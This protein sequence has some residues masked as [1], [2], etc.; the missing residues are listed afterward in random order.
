MAEE[1]RV[2]LSRAFGLVR[3]R[4]GCSRRLSAC[5]SRMADGC[6]IRTHGGFRLTR[7]QNERLN[8]LEPT[9]QELFIMAGAAGFEPAISVLETGVLPLTLCPYQ[10]GTA[11][12][13]RTYEGQ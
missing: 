2:E 11:G 4:N 6:G 13:T 7:F 3:F 5:S 1:E 8:P 12:R 9:L 10:N